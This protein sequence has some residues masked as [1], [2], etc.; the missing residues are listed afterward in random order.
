MFHLKLKE[1]LKKE[2]LLLNLIAKLFVYWAFSSL[3]KFHSRQRT[4]NRKGNDLAP[5]YTRAP[6]FFNFWNLS[7]NV[8]Q[9]DPVGL[10]ACEYDTTPTGVYKTTP[11][12][13]HSHKTC[14]VNCEQCI[15]VFSLHTVM[16]IWNSYLSCIAQWNTLQCF[17][18]ALLGFQSKVRRFHAWIHVLSRL[19]IGGLEYYG[20]KAV[21]FT[22]VELSW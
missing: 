9:A 18:I 1:L 7:R 16:R 13:E 4:N 21:Y 6:S 2:V 12:G 11:T 8:S 22:Q 5:I 19:P 17:I 3:K 15:G 20:L 14:T 10:E